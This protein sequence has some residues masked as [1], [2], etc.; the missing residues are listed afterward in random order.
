[1]LCQP[2]KKPCKS[3]PLSEPPQ[4]TGRAGLT[5][6]QGEQ[7]RQQ[8]RRAERSPL[9]EKRDSY[10]AAHADAPKRLQTR[11]DP[12]RPVDE[13]TKPQPTPESDHRHGHP[14]ALVDHVP[15][16]LPETLALPHIRPRLQSPLDLVG[17]TGQSSSSQ[18]IDLAKLEPRWRAV[19]ASVAMSL[20]LLLAMM[21]LFKL[22]V[23]SLMLWI[24][25][26][27]DS[28]VAS[29]AEEDG[30]EGEDEGGTKTLGGPPRAPHPRL[31]LPPHPRRRGPH[32][33]PA[34][35]SPARVRRSASRVLARARVHP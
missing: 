30:S 3:S 9:D 19:V 10:D 7:P 5:Q 17:H 22:V 26:R 2:R 35:P 1:M 8:Q 29:L 32:G 27:T 15:K 24:P 33:S 25:F 13:Q 4:L 21:G 16:A 34:A 23:A 11:Q 20:W 31:P 6:P 12:S 18:P 14:Q 28:A